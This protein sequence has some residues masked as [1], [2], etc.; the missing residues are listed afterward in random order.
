MR[1]LGLDPID[2]H[3]YLGVG[4]HWPWHGYGA[5]LRRR[6]RDL[7]MALTA[8][9][10][11]PGPVDLALRKGQDARNGYAAKVRACTSGSSR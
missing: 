8:Y 1:R 9:N 7:E 2:G 6:A 10:R 3:P 5:P 11:R 4:A